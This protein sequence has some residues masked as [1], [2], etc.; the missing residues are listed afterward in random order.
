MKKYALEVRRR[1]TGTAT[2]LEVPTSGEGKRHHKQ[3]RI[4]Q[5]VTAGPE[6]GRNSEYPSNVTSQYPV[7]RAHT[8]VTAHEGGS[9]DNRTREKMRHPIIAES[10]KMKISKPSFDHHGWGKSSGMIKTSLNFWFSVWLLL[11]RSR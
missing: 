11:A 8:A 2:W 6:T 10:F 1:N 4:A 3:H 7:I 5:L 9:K